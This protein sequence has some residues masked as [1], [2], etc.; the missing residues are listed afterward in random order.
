MYGYSNPVLSS[1]SFLSSCPL[2]SCELTGPLGEENLQDLL[3]V[4]LDRLVEG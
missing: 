2:G 4:F 1:G 3:V